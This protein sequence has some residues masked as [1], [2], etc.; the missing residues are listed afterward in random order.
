MS[1][2]DGQVHAR[3]PV[4]PPPSSAPRPVPSSPLSTPTCAL[5]PRL[6]ADC[7]L[8]PR[9]LLVSEGCL[10]LLSLRLGS[11]TPAWPPGPASVGSRTPHAGSGLNQ[12]MVSLRLWAPQRE[13]GHSSGAAV[14]DPVPAKPQAS[15]VVLDMEARAE[16]DGCAAHTKLL[17]VTGSSVPPVGAPPMSV[18]FCAC[19]FSVAKKRPENQNPRATGSCLWF[20]PQTVVRAFAFTTDRVCG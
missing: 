10:P 7:P 11:G 3:Q 4:C 1:C 6:Y 13:R 16:P 12:H 18:L 17:R 2:W 20:P 14:Q 15:A 9:A 19:K 8:R 5:C